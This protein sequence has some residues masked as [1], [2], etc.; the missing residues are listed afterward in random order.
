VTALSW[1]ARLVFIVALLTWLSFVA[2][3]AQQPESG[4]DVKRRTAA[5]LVMVGAGTACLV[6]APKKPAADEEETF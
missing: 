2:K 4:T 1:L 5:F 3:A 6:L